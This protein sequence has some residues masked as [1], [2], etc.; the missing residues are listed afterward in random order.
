MQ[1]MGGVVYKRFCQITINN[2]MLRSVFLQAHFNCKKTFSA[3]PVFV[4]HPTGLGL[5]Q[6]IERIL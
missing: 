6:S 5:G 1:G 3:K 2:P 4:S